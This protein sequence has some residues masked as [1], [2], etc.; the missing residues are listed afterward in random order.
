MYIKARAQCLIFDGRFDR[1]EREKNTRMCVL[2][3]ALIA[4]ESLT[5]FRKNKLGAVLQRLIYAALIILVYDAAIKLREFGVRLL[6][7]CGSLLFLL[8]YI[9]IGNW[10][11]NSVRL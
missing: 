2:T 10:W 9:F 8:T 4:R 1:R 11:L 7:R 5:D 3:R 6:Q